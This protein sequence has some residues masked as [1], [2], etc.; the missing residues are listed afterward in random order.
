MTFKSFCYEMWLEYMEEC[1]TYNMRAQPYNNWF[2]Q[3]K[4]FVRK[5]YRARYG[6]LQSKWKSNFDRN[7]TNIT[8]S[9]SYE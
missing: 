2:P 6:K 7:L 9:N 8:P 4:W 3:N 1:L 5:V